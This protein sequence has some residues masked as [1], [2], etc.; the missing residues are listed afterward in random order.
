MPAREEERWCLL[1]LNSAWWE[2]I[3][4][5]VEV[6]QRRSQ[7]K[8]VWLEAGGGRCWARGNRAPC[9][10]RGGHTT[11]KGLL[12]SAP[13]LQL[14][15][16][17]SRLPVS[18][19][20]VLPPVSGSGGQGLNSHPRGSHFPELLLCEAPGRT[21]A[22]AGSLQSLEHLWPPRTARSTDEAQGNRKGGGLSSPPGGARAPATWVLWL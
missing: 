8:A 20:G 10:T 14:L 22:P 11:A 4:A 5:I 16:T 1:S 12:L 21:L 7:S 3:C 9:D 19:P 13:L 17:P 18:Q 2:S 6:G 15:G